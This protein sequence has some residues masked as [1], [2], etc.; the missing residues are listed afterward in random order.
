MLALLPCL[1]WA[2]FDDWFAP[3]S[4]RVD[5]TLTGNNQ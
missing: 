3:S 1:A 5:Y 4:M 2:Q